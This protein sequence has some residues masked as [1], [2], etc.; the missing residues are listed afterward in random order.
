MADRRS[1]RSRRR[2][3]SDLNS[4]DLIRAVSNHPV[5]WDYNLP[6]FHVREKMEAACEEVAKKFY[7]STGLY[8]FLLEIVNLIGLYPI[9]FEKEFFNF[10]VSFSGQQVYLHWKGLVDRRNRHRQE[11]EK[12]E[13][14]GAPAHNKRPFKYAR[15]MSFLNTVQGDKDLKGETSTESEDDS[16]ELSDASEERK[17]SFLDLTMERQ[18]SAILHRLVRHVSHQG[19]S[20]IVP[21]KIPYSDC[22]EVIR[23]N[24]PLLLCVVLC[25]IYIHLSCLNIR[26]S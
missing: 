3:K 23:T 26:R 7:G 25:L 20:D 21:H 5:I 1:S 6:E 18:D 16:E 4:T 22:D 14:S 17:G 12:L 10:Y 19:T 2:P 8:L 24:F 15:E 13:R 11:T 9:T